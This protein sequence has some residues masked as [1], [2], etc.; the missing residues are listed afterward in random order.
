[1]MTAGGGVFTAVL[2]HDS[3]AV[4]HLA[5]LAFTFAFPH[6]P[7]CFIFHLKNFYG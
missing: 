7:L 5:N 6:V 2:P 1:M 4:T 3:I